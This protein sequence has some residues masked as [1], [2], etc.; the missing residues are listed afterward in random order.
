MS[1]K[2]AYV[3][4][5]TKTS[6]LAG[7]IVLDYG[8]RSV[9]S[10]YPLVVMVTPSLPQDAI[11]ILEKRGIKTRNV[12]S[13]EPKPGV[14]TLAGHDARFADTWTKLSQLNSGTVVLNP[15]GDLS[16]SIVHFLWNHDKVSEFAFPDQDLLTAFFSG[17]WKPIPWYYN[18][19]RT[20]RYTHPDEWSDDEVRCVHY[21]LPDKPWHSRVTPLELEAQL[22]ETN[23][24][25]WAQFDKL[26]MEMQKL[27]PE[28]WNLL[29]TTVDNS[30]G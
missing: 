19:L 18:A 16:N 9:N 17:R 12:N 2:A 14:H 5:L 10:K 4:L 15:S 13:L 30:R 23:R 28:G 24:W 8:L 11:N 26:A 3:T 6:Y 25:W 29:L 1:P 21:I 20:L 27:D 7:T 22:G